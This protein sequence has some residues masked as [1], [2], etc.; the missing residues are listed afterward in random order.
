MVSAMSVPN[1]TAF[2]TSGRVDAEALHVYLADY[3]DVSWVIHGLLYGFSLHYD[4][5]L[6]KPSRMLFSRFASSAEKQAALML[7]GKELT[8]GRVLGPFPEVP[9]AEYLPHRIFLVPK[10]EAPIPFR[11]I[12][13]F[14][15]PKSTALNSFVAD[16]W[17]TVK[18]PSVD[19]AADHIIDLKRGA[20][21]A[22][23]DILD[24]YRNL[25]LRREDWPL[26]VFAIDD[27]FFVDTRLVLGAS[28]ACQ[29]FQRFSL[30]LRWIVC[31]RFPTVRCVVLIDDFLFIGASAD[32]SNLREAFAFFARLCDVINLPLNRKKTVSPTTCLTYLGVELDSNRFEARLDLAK[33]E[34][35]RSCLDHA[36]SVDTLT[37]KEIESLV[38]LLQWSCRVLRGARAFLRRLIDLGSDL[39]KPKDSISLTTEVKEDLQIWKVFIDNFN[40]VSFLL[41]RDIF[42]CDDLVFS[43]DS[44]GSFGYGV[45]C[46]PSWAYG[47]WSKNWLPFPIHL[48]EMFAIFLGISLW[49]EK[50]RNVKLQIFCDN[51]VCCNVLNRQT[52]KDKFLLFFL[53]KIVLLCLQLN[54]V[55]RATYI[56]SKQNRRADLLSR[57]QVVT[58]LQES[59][60]FSATP[61]EIPFSLQPDTVLSDF[62]N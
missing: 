24:G 45:L 54:L 62:L 37:K 57:N 49:K 44:S 46:H 22:K 2:T 51:A 28:A 50:F 18:Y 27:S 58:F 20:L 53:R 14:S 13:D 41:Y 42:T 30:A 32:E 55:I 12:H 9:F 21:L 43:S 56:P 5:P 26:T 33:L 7:I 17:K 29:C 61:T 59:P 48:K 31:D 15:N 25:P 60:T 40:G 11:L 35:L 8:L 34:R 38:G 16:I 19:L 4:G 1:A 23:L 3:R 6:R 10:P 47:A 52:S 39:A 36:L